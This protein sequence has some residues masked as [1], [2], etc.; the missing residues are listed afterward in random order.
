MIGAAVR[1]L[2]RGRVL[3]GKAL[4]IVG[5]AVFL[6]AVIAEIRGQSS[7]AAR[8]RDGGGSRQKADEADDDV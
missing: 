6:G 2:S 7:H 1:L 4:G 8:G 5:S 3:V